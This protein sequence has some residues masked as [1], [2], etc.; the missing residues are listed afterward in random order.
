LTVGRHGD[1]D[2]TGTSTFVIHVLDDDGSAPTSLPM[3]ARVA[4]SL[5]D[6]TL[7]G[8]NAVQQPP[9]TVRF[10]DDAGSCHQ[11]VRCILYYRHVIMM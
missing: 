6:N 4:M 2:V 8:A 10:N 1:S 3:M 9:L 7:G 11:R 5:A